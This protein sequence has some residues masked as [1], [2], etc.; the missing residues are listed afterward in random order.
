MENKHIAVGKDV[1]KTVLI[2]WSVL[3]SFCGFTRQT[4]VVLIIKVRAR[5][6]QRK[7]TG[8]CEAEP[9]IYIFKIKI[10]L[11]CHW[12]RK[13]FFNSSAGQYGVT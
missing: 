9:S 6:F 5:L 2:S 12:E 10:G 3:F 8:S 1:K 4:A 7:E 11:A 13:T